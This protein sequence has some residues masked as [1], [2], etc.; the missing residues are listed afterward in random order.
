MS[1]KAEQTRHHLRQVL[2]T[3]I[4][5]EAYEA[6]SMKD[7]SQRANVSRSTLY[8]HYQTKDE[9]FLDCMREHI[10]TSK[11]ELPPP[12]QIPPKQT[13]TIALHIL[14]SFY[15]NIANN[16]AFYK[17]MM[18][19]PTIGNQAQR[20]F[21][22][23]GTG[24]MILLMENS[25]IFRE[26]PAPV[27]I[28]TH[29]VAEAQIGLAIWWLES[30]SSHSP[31]LMAEIAMRMTERGIFGFGPWPGSPHDVTERPFGGE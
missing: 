10:E 20:Q 2:M 8:R 27:D 4:E 13:G 17:V 26:F 1:K 5:Q 30:N 25:G 16:R 3:L 28:V 6:I 22:R 15:Q 11:I 21:R 14:I 29:Y 9:L 12:S 18:T 23:Y 24:L 31:E 19:A 7:I